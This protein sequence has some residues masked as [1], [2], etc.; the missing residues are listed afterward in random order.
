MPITIE[1]MEELLKEYEHWIAR[2]REA[3]DFAEIAWKDSVMPDYD[4]AYSIYAVLKPLGDLPDNCARAERKHIRG[5]IKR[6]LWTRERARLRRRQNGTPERPV[7]TST[8]EEGKR[9]Y[10]DKFDPLT[11]DAAYELWNA[12]GRD[13]A[14]ERAHAQ[15]SAVTQATPEKKLSKLELLQLAAKEQTTLDAEDDPNVLFEDDVPAQSKE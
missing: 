13:L 3:I 4:K 8:V 5:N 15:E 11:G 14:N 2:V 12:T 7:V 1:R 9:Y 6:I 10:N